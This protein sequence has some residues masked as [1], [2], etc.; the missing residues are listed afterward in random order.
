MSDNIPTISEQEFDA[1]VALTPGIPVLVDFSATWCGPC[2]TLAG[3]LEQIAL[4]FAGKVR[5]VKVD[6]DEAPELVK[7]FKIRGV[8]MIVVFRDG[9]P[10]ETWIGLTTR[11]VILRMLGI[12]V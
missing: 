11:E 6:I 5:I 8:P 12:E 9:Q 3:I 4:D 1:N 7:R 2:K 10:A